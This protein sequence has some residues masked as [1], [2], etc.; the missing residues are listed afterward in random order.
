MEDKNFIVKKINDKDAI[1]LQFSGNLIINYINDIKLN[2]EKLNVF[3]SNINVKLT[4]VDN[5]DFTFVQL[6][7][8]MQKTLTDVR[9]SFSVSSKLNED[10]TNLLINAGF[11]KF[12]SLN[13]N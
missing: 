11:N 13:I 6:L 3:D 5:L 12:M 4:Q 2:V 7:L 8:S 10:L 9:Y 1:T